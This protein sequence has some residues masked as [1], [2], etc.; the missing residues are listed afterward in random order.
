MTTK[1]HLHEKL[2]IT[3][4]ELLGILAVREALKMGLLVTPDRH[5][6]SDTDNAYSVGAKLALQG[7]HV[8]TM[9]EWLYKGETFLNSENSEK[10]PN[11]HCGT[12]ACI[13][14]HMQLMGIA[15]L[16]DIPDEHPL[17]RLFYPDIDESVMSWNDIT[18]KQT[19]KAIDNFLVNGN[20]KW[21]EVVGQVKPRKRV[22]KKAK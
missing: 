2:G 19:I 9:G 10:Y 22:V 13:G 11:A 16:I 7:D 5:N 12:V 17:H 4:A 21:K 15:G 18:P 8:F 3:F 6:R 20:P 1:Q 14:G